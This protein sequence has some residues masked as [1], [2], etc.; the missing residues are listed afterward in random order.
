MLSVLSKLLHL[1]KQS[2]ITAVH[3]PCR[4]LSLGCWTSNGPWLF[5]CWATFSM[6]TCE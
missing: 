2:H 1:H 6:I 5:T 3:R 4:V